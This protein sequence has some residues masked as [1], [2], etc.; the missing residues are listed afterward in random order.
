MGPGSVPVAT[1]AAAVSPSVA[2]VS[3]AG[4]LLLEG[5]GEASAG[6]VVVGGFLKAAATP[7]AGG[8]GWGLLTPH[9]RS[10]PPQLFSIFG[11]IGFLEVSQ[12]TERGLP[13]PVSPTL[14][15]QQYCW[16][17][18]TYLVVGKFFGPGPRASGRPVGARGRQGCEEGR[19]RH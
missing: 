16:S 12:M 6:T 18:K 7:L 15:S 3:S 4:G 14:S 10:F 17:P 5:A 19:T 9:A 11:P 2:S 8:A 1:T 13:S